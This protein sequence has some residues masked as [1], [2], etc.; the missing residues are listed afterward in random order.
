MVGRKHDWDYA[1]RIR[2]TTPRAVP[3]ARLGEYLKA[4]AA[5][6]GDANSP[7]YAGVVNGSALL[8]ASVEPDRKAQT[9]TRLLAVS[10]GVDD[11]L[12]KANDTLA[13]MLAADGLSGAVEDRSGAVILEFRRPDL[14]PDAMEHVVQDVGIVD[15]VVVGLQGIDDTV[16]LR[17]LGGD[18]QS[19]KVTVRDL[20][21]ARQLA[22]HFRGEML[23][24]HLHGSW[25]RG[26]E[27]RWEPHAIYL[28]R[29]EELSD[30]PVG[31][32]LSRLS[33]L[34]GNR[35][36]TMDAPHELLRRL[37]GDD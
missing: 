34:P 16:H 17:L 32:L 31:E 25:K 35:W 5:L 27:G 8:R 29:F 14:D 4:Y 24:V 15:G 26:P 7:T 12:L 28:D 22:V 37:R 10:A 30:E 2:G 21:Q 23:R 6:L 18:G 20:A 33:A 19:I 9:R 13:Q 36:A 11:A 3:L 1:L